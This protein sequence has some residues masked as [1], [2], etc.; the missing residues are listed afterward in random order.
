MF[1]PDNRRKIDISITNDGELAFKKAQTALG[2]FTDNIFKKFTE[3][4][5]QR[6]REILHKIR[7]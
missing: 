7:E 4:E 1:C 6:L 5:A 2:N 3:S